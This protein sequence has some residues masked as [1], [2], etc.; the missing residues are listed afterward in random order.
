MPERPRDPLRKPP[1]FADLGSMMGVGL[2]F[3]AA[4]V[5]FF[6]AG[7]WLDGVLGTRPWLMLVGA[8]IGGV[9]GFYSM[10]VKLVVA[11]ERRRRER[12]PAPH[13]GRA[14]DQDALR[15]H[16]PA[17]RGLLD[18]GAHRHHAHQVR[19]LPLA[20]RRCWCSL[21]FLPAG[22]R[23][24]VRGARGAPRGGHNA[25]EAMVLFF[26]DKVVMPN[27]GH[28]GEKYVPFVVTLFFFILIANLLGLVPYGGS[29]TANISVTAAL[30]LMSL[31][32]IETRGCG[33]GLQ[34]LHEHDL[35]LEQGP[36]DP[37]CGP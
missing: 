20:H 27:I 36:A 6:F 7:Y 18:A 2:Q 24:S 8:L 19:R 28:G 26:R 16:P 21:L 25:I 35:L 29:V 5:L 13:P 32:V 12:H 30:A 23:R 3:G 14:R 17:A 31:V 9:A 22:R 4:I 10:Y 34:G 1:P 15:V 33:A 37:A 11:P